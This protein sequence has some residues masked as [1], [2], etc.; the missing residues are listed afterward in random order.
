MIRRVPFVFAVNAALILLSGVLVFHVLV[1]GGVVPF[2]IVWGGRLQR[3]DQMRAFESV[4][5]LITFLVL[6]TV[7][8]RGGYVSRFL[9][10]RVLSIL[11]GV[12][13]GIF[14]LNTVGNIFALT[15]IEAIIGAPLTFLISLLC[16]RMAVE[17]WPQGVNGHAG[18]L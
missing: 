10:T 5:V 1:L 6:G 15:T 8:M 2:E 9:P 3:V 14:A 17:P 7:A 12:Y 16:W 4:S 13:G 11:L 18:P